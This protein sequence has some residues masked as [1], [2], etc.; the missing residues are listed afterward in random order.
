MKAE[1]EVDRVTGRWK[2]EEIRQPRNRQP[3]EAAKSRTQILS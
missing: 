1:V 2:M 3:L